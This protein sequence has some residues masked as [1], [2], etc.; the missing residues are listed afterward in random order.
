MSKHSP[1]PYRCPSYA[2]SQEHMIDTD[3]WEK[4]TQTYTLQAEAWAAKL[5]LD[6]AN[7]QTQN[8]GRKD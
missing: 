3:D 2:V 4:S 6:P 1:I 7:C 5:G 8:I